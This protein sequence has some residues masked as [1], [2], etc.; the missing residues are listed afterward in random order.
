MP[1]SI[2][3]GDLDLNIAHPHG[4][5]TLVPS[6]ALEQHLDWR[7]MP[8]QGDGP[9]GPRINADPLPPLAVHLH[10]HYLETLPKLLNALN[11]CRTGI[12]GLRLWISTDRSAKADAITEALQQHPI[13]EEATTIAVRVCPNRGR[14]LGPL[15]HHLWPE[16]QQEALVLHLHGKRSRETNLGDAWLEQLLTCLLPDGDTVLALRQQFHSDPNLGVVMP[17]PP[18]LIRPYLNWGMNF[19]LARQLARA[20]GQQL[21]RD[22]VLVFPAGGMFW[23]RPAALAPLTKCV[24]ALETLPP[25]PLAVDGSSLHAIERLV[26]HACEGSGHHW[27]LACESQPAPASNISPLSVLMPLPDELQQATAFLAMQCRRLHHITTNLE[28]SNQQLNQQFDSA[29]Q[30]LSKA[31]STIKE[32][33]QTLQARDQEIQTMA[34][35]WGWKLTRLWQRLWQQAGT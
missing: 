17:Q 25:E 20:M 7:L 27:R 2:P 6:P 11:A 33:V 3:C 31:D 30:Q 35:S 19:E 34:S 32:L 18:E 16:L 5:P 14:N 9:M 23:A 21:H 26:A 12:Q 15:L 29:N 22:A 4:M 24:Q 1:S 13:A 8:A 10:V 28:R